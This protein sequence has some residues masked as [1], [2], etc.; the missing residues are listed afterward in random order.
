MAFADQVRQ[1]FFDNGALTP[2]ASE[3]RYGTPT[4]TGVGLA[5]E[6]QYAMFG[7]SARWGSIPAS[8]QGPFPNTQAA[9]AATANWI[10]G[11]YLPQRT[12]IVL[13]Q[14]QAA[15]LYPTTSAAEYY[16]NGTVQYGGEFTPGASLTFGA[17]GG[18]SWPVGT[19]IYYTTDGTDPRLLGGGINPAS[20]V[21]V[22]SG[23]ITMSQGMVLKARAYF[24]GTWSA[25][26]NATFY[27]ILTGLRVTEVNYDPMPATPAEIAAGYTIVD[28]TD[29]N[30][31]FQFIEI[32]NTN[33]AGTAAMPLAGLELDGGVTYTVPSDST[34][35][36][37]PGSYMVFVADEAAFTIR[38][39]AELEAQFGANWQS[40]I[41]I[42]QFDHHLS[43]SSDEIELDSP[44]G[45]IE[46]FTYDGQWYSQCHASQPSLTLTGIT[47]S[48][49]TA[50]AT[51][52]ASDGLSTGEEVEILGGHA[53]TVRRDI[54]RHRHQQY[55]IYVHH[56]KRRGPTPRARSSAVPFLD[57][58]Y[59]LVAVS[60]AQRASVWSAA[61]TASVWSTSAAWE[62]S[63]VPGGT[64][65][66]ADPYSIPLPGV[67][68][69]DEVLANPTTANGDMIKLY[70]ASAAAINVGG[71]WLSNNPADLT[72]YQIAAGT[73]IAAGGYLVLTDAKNY[74]AASGDPGVMVPFALS[75]DGFTVCLSSN[76]GGAAGGY[77]V[78]QTYG[79][80][81]PGISAGLVTTSTGAQDFVI[82]S[83]PAFGQPTGG[84]YPGA[85]NSLAFVSPIVMT[86]LQYDPSDPTP[87]E[88]AAGFTDGDDFEYLELYNRSNTTQTLSN[89]YMGNGVGFTFGWV[90]DGTA[91]ESETLESGATATW[92]TSALAAGTYTV[93]ADYDLTDPNGNTR[94]VDSGAQ[95]TI[96]YPGGSIKVTADQSTAVNGALSLGP[97]TTT[98]PGQV[99]VQLTRQ[100]TTAPSQWTLANQVEFVGTGI[101]LKVGNPTLTS[102]ATT[103]G[104]T[105]LAPGPT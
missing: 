85:A 19:V 45:T 63:S 98:G 12:G 59:A 94:N 44:N 33:A 65:G 97:I 29:P 89:Y 61:G 54:H 2:A 103:S 87:A 27:P 10:D 7:E 81:L 38:Y 101:D 86:E 43:D 93:Y 47:A 67:I 22:Y 41:V 64:P 23:P 90:P 5:S 55:A 25:L 84:V 76:A 51:C 18:G 21:D 79:A 28:T 100:S 75:P 96:T 72:E 71:W 78:Q 8:V 68:E 52:S 4:P 6:I 83:A 30:K 14:L 58:G 40:E 104:L 36:I 13:S 17:L 11:T 34:Q 92:T 69:I 20:D 95:Y 42:G 57:D 15:G 99:T 39:G 80:T 88:T 49:T 74:G 60:P 62:A 9:W 37:A 82:L 16:V 102:F 35:I 46:D 53:G 91:N 1:M 48:G 32:E 31:D 26:S 3:A 77:Q 56:D 66:F 70:N 50:T 73:S 24:N 105:T